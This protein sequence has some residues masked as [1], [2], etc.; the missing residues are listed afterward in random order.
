MPSTRVPL[1]A[2]A[3]V[4]LLATSGVAA[5]S[6]VGPAPAD[7]GSQ[8][9]ATAQT[10]NTTE[11]AGTGHAGPE[12]PGMAS[13]HSYTLTI[14]DASDGAHLHSLRLN[15]SGTGVVL[16]DGLSHYRAWLV[17][18]PA[19]ANETE[20]RLANTSVDYD[21]TTVTYTFPDNRTLAAGDELVVSV[22]G[23]ENP[24]ESGSIDV[25][26]SLNP[27]AGPTGT[28]TLDIRT[29]APTISPQG[30][31]GDITR[32]GIHDPRGA[33]GFI[34]AYDTEGTVLGMY[35]LDPDR[36]LRMDVGV[37]AF[38]EDPA[39]QNGMTVRLV[40]HQDSNGNDVF[41]PDTDEPFFRD[42][43]P[44]Q[45]TIQNAV[46][47]GGTKPTEQPPCPSV[48]F[49]YEAEE[50]VKDGVARVDYGI[51]SNWSGFVVVETT[52]GTVLG[53]TDLLE[54]D[55]GV[56]ADGASIELSNTPNGTH[57]VRV[58]AYRDSDGNGEF[59]QGRDEPCAG[60]DVTEVEFGGSTGTTSTTSPTTATTTP[61]FGVLVGL[62]SVL[63]GVL[64]VRHR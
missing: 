31:V 11:L 18:D 45:A 6:A 51:D 41:D 37:G 53:H 12:A 40:A 1:I 35:T 39:E 55:T 25:G 8:P 13:R 3:V 63:L 21:N 50:P 4:S 14:P 22:S 20:I 24:P 58:V 64:L 48:G 19:T 16:S 57:D 2:I 44:V 23:L 34:V 9:L 54:Y 7:S 42:G 28:I 60:G 43:N 5:A 38:V 27:P 29:P 62:F 10:G 47:S 49:W 32:V 56:H 33:Q 46:F 30:V 36:D 26:V 15:Y 61:G 52:D 59:D 17:E